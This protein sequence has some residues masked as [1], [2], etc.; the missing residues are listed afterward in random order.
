MTAKTP[1][2]K[3]AAPKAKPAA[4]KPKAKTAEQVPYNKLRRPT[5]TERFLRFLSRQGGATIKEMQREIKMQTHSIRGAMSNL[6]KKQ[7]IAIIY[8]RETGK[9]RKA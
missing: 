3:T 5:N 4:K 6:K 1:S 8:D 9:Y 7:G 2:K